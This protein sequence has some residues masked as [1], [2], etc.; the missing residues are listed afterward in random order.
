MRRAG[1]GCL[2]R[3]NHFLADVSPPQWRPRCPFQGRGGK[4]GLSQAVRRTPEARSCTNAVRKRAALT[5]TRASAEAG[6]KRGRLERRV[7]E[8]IRDGVSDNA[9]T[10]TRT[11]VV[12]NRRRLVLEGRIEKPGQTDAGLFSPAS[13]GG[14]GVVS[15]QASVGRSR[16]HGKAANEGYRRAMGLIR[17]AGTVVPTTVGASF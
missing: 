15:N 5:A 9:R 16:S 11:A 12:S 8:R 10:R 2:C 7:C 3:H 4:A 1:V 13:S 6:T 14:P 17:C